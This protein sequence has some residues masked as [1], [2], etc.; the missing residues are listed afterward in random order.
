[1]PNLLDALKQSISTA[2]P[3]GVQP[4]Y[5]PDILND[6]V[7]KYGSLD[8]ATEAIQAARAGEASADPSLTAL[9]PEQR[10]QYDRYTNFAQ[11]AQQAPQNPVAKAALLGGGLANMAATDISKMTGADKLLS[12]L[13]NK[14]YGGGGGEGGD[15]QFFGGK[16]ESAPNLVPNLLA[17]YRGFTR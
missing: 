3:A 7:K 8:K 2:S 5:S 6:F 13:Y 14:I 17:A 12:T 15:T 4:A 11:M 9:S 1:M 10:A 16:D